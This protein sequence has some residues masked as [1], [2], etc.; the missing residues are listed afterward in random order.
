MGESIMRLRAFGAL[1]LAAAP[2]WADPS[3]EAKA[4]GAREFVEDISLSPDGNKVAIVRPIGGRKS[5]LTIAAFDGKEPRAILRSTGDPDRLR[6]C[7][8]VT[9]DRLVCHMYLL[10]KDMGDLLGFTRLI[11]INADGGDLKML[12]E[13]PGVNALR[14]LQDGGNVIDLTG[15]GGP[16]SVLMTHEYVP[17][18]SVGTRLANEKDGVGVDAV[19]TVTLARRPVEQPKSAAVEYITDGLGKVRVMG[20]R[21][22]SSTGY[23]ENTLAYFYRKPDSRTWERL[24]TYRLSGGADAGFNP[25][26]VDPALNVVYGFD[27]AD[28]RRALYRIALDGSMKK[29]LVVARPDVDVDEL[30][31]IGRQQRVVGASWATER[32]EAAFFDPE[33]QKLRVALGKAIPKLPKIRFVDASA[34]EKALLLHAS[35]DDDPGRYYLFHKDNRHLEDVMPARPELEGMTLATMKPVSY[36]AADGTTIPAYLTLPPGSNGKNLPAIV[37]PHGGPAARDEWGF[38]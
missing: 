6:S 35:S 26:S 15:D 13:Q 9:A 20:T 25:F 19:D 34:D 36:R 12:T 33:L 28:G 18:K 21:G 5:V 17:E 29:E 7:Q 37:M 23:S 38:D 16:G 8:W 31:R 22:T 24:G 30:I 1:L 14:I 27:D 10:S 4:F 32:R 11:A 3:R 2:A